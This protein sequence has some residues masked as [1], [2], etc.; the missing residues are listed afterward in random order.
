LQEQASHRVPSRRSRVRREA[1]ESVIC[2]R[3]GADTSMM[4]GRGFP[5]SRA[6]RAIATS[7]VSPLDQYLAAQVA[8]VPSHPTTVQPGPPRLAACVQVPSQWHD[9][10][11]GGM[12]DDRSRAARDG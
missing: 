1:D 6:E 4:R 2:Y 11:Y 5:A 12:G 8:D 3:R 10:G 9:G 7:S